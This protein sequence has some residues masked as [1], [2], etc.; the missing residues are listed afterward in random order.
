[1]SGT[2]SVLG[3]A[4]ESS[5]VEFPV[6]TGPGT[7]FAKA[8][9]TIMKGTANLPVLDV[10][11]DSQ[12]EK[13]DFGYVYQ[14][15]H[16]QFPDGQTG[17]MRGHVIGLQGDFTAF[18]YGH[19]TEMKHAYLMVRDM[20]K[21]A[22]VA[23]A[24]AQQQKQQD[25][26]AK[27]EKTAATATTTTTTS[28][29]TEQVAPIMT[30]QAGIARPTGAPTA[31][32]KTAA[33]AYVRNAPSTVGTQRLFTIPRNV[34]VPILQIAT[35]ESSRHFRWYKVAYQN[36]EAWIREDLVTYD[37][38]TEAIGLPWDLYPAPMD[39]RW[40]V[41]DY[42][43]QPLFDP[44]TW[45][46]AGWDY[47]AKEGELIRCG[48]LGG[49]VVKVVD[50]TKCTPDKPST[51]SQG[52]G[53]NDSSV[54]TDEG[55]GDGYGTYVIVRYTNDQLPDSTKTSI[56]TMGYPGG[57]VFVLYGHLR[58]RKV[59]EGQ[60]L[61]PHQVIG[62]CG[63]TGNSEAP[64]LHLEVRVSPTDQWNNWYFIRGGL[65]SPVILFKR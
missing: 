62:S 32:V 24:K 34:G 51:V 43:R 61:E 31:M 64:H 23:A 7:T 10:Q 1:M 25:D 33:S 22:A 44:N 59:I 55:W 5:V 20:E 36:Q 45:E 57:S 63:N 60:T 26:P 6:R 39:E 12:G 15:F 37:G 19:V 47:G 29:N 42:N 8:P 41:R 56:S 13:S 21:A 2:A 58:D 11:P 17:W 27:I 40:W 38:D 52:L 46:H 30:K 14:W 28:T 18:G 3:F 9:F 50:C 48:P 35:E 53:L 65:T 49:T 54:F 16:L 4:Y